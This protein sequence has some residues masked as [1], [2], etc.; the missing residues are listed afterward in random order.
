MKPGT[1]HKRTHKP[2]KHGSRKNGGSRH[3]ERARKEKPWIGG[4]GIYVRSRRGRKKPKKAPSAIYDR[5]TFCGSYAAFAEEEEAPIIWRC[6]LG[7]DS[8]STKCVKC[9]PRIKHPQR[10]QLLPWDYHH[11]GHHNIECDAF[12]AELAGQLY[13]DTGGDAFRVA[14]GVPLSQKHKGIWW[15]DAQPRDLAV[16]GALCAVKRWENTERRGSQYRQLA[17]V[18]RRIAKHQRVPPAE[19]R[20]ALVEA[21]LGARGITLPQ[22][23]NTSKWDYENDVR[24]D[25]PSLLTLVDEDHFPSSALASAAI[26]YLVRKGSDTGTKALVGFGLAAAKLARLSGAIEDEMVVR[27]QL[28]RWTGPGGR[29]SDEVID[30]AAA[31][32]GAGQRALAKRLV[33]RETKGRKRQETRENDNREGSSR[34]SGSKRKRRRGP[35]ARGRRK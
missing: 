16:F 7:C 34:R 28:P 17:S 27:S 15:H 32:W 6:L 20:A 12:E 23:W 4:D 1:R 31:A 22:R 10:S 29:V 13:H 5:C 30:A 35:S 8:E 25:P 21:D 19:V 33:K 9:F 24:I 26:G 14:A 2:G 18:V 11:F 3:A